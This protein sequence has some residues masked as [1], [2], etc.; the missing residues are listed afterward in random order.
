MRVSRTTLKALAAATWYTGG[1]V[2]AYK[3][4]DWLLSAASTGVDAAPLVAGLL[5]VLVGLARGR[6][7][8]LKACLRNLRRIDALPAPRV[9]Q[10]YRPGFFAALVLMLL[11]GALLAWIASRG[12]WE[13]VVVGGLEMMIGT[14]LLSSSTAFWRSP[15]GP[16][17]AEA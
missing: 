8:F 15:E 16:E 4:V 12:Y 6:T 1:G 5:G 3:G 14:A 13:A 7:M 10:F 9:W 11:A 17:P 2:L